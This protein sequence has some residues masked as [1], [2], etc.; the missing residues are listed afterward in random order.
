MRKR[1]DYR[2]LVTI[3]Q[4]FISISNAFLVVVV[5]IASLHHCLSFFKQDFDISSQDTSMVSETKQKQINR[6][7]KE[8]KKRRRKSC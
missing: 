2:K 7:T 5:I 8:R 6:Q 3:A 4:V 1:W